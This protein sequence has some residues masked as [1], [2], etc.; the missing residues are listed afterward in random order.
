MS[1]D[2]HIRTT[3]S[4][5]V[6]DRTKKFEKET[7]MKFR[8]FVFAT[9]LIL[10][11]SFATHARAQVTASKEVR[12]PSSITVT[13]S[14]EALQSI[15]VKAPAAGNLVIIATGTMIYEH[16]E[17]TAG[18]FCLQL[19]DISGYVGGCEPDATDSAI[20]SYIAPGQA[21]S[22]SQ[23]T[24]VPYSIVR[25]WP[26]KAGVTYKFYLNGNA[27]GFESASLFQPAITAIYVQGTLNP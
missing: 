14:S 8:A 1:L 13:D 17:G 6:I 27:G 5:V 19:W 21:S 3:E 16:T 10:T 26:V 23:G 4:L 24:S 2:R 25:T 15:E 18:S 20:R 7:P 12:G 9:T 11:G 22:A